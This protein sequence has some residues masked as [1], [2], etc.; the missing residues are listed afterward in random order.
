M[1]PGILMMIG[2]WIAAAGGLLTGILWLRQRNSDPASRAA[3]RASLRQR[4]ESGELDPE[5]YER[6][7]AALERD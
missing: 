4:L 7:L 6:R 5:E 3:I 1:K 2:F